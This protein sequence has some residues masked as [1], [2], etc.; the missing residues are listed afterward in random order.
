MRPR[1]S[2]V[3][4]PRVAGGVNILAGAEWLLVLRVLG[5]LI[6]ERTFFPAEGI[7]V[8]L[9]FDQILPDLGPDAFEDPAHMAEDGVVPEDRVLLL[10]DVPEAERGEDH[11]RDEGDQ[12]CLTPGGTDAG[13]DHEQD[14]DREE[15]VAG[16]V[17]PSGWCEGD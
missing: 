5:A 15:R 1:R 10:Q 3:Q 2:R 6:D 8:A 11:E 7:L 9:A 4:Q 12:A 14:N 17:E 16:Q 13:R